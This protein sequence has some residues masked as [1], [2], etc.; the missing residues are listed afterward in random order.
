[1]GLATSQ[2]LL[3]LSATGRRTPELVRL[4]EQRCQGPTMLGFFKKNKNGCD[5]QY[6]YIYI[7]IYIG[8]QWGEKIL[9]LPK[10][11]TAGP[12]GGIAADVEA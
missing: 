9:A 2:V 6:I 12:S 4:F 5:A 11:A 1:M 8:H 10:S 3:Y 7:Y